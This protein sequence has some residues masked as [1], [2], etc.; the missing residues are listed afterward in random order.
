MPISARETAKVVRSE[1][2]LSFFNASTLATASS[3]ALIAAVNC[4]LALSY[5]FL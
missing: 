1:S 5:L 2:L 4:P 3:A